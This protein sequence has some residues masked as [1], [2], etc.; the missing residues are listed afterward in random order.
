MRLFDYFRNPA[1]YTTCVLQKRSF[2]TRKDIRP[3][4]SIETLTLVL[5]GLGNHQEKLSEKITQH[6]SLS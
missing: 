4:E 2:K 1:V 6:H 5:S 3:F